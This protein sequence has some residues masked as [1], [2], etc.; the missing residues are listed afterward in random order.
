MSDKILFQGELQMTAWGESMTT[1]SWVKFWVH[2]EDMDVFKHKLRART[3]KTTGTRIGSVMVEIGDDEAIVEHQDTP[4]PTPAPPPLT[5][6]AEKPKP[7]PLGDLGKWAVM[8]CRDPRFQHWVALQLLV[9][10]DADDRAT[11]AD[12]KAFILDE[13]GAT[14]RYGTAASRKHLDTDPQCRASFTARV[15]E[16]YR[17][18]YQQQGFTE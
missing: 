15:L 16:P 9:D 12:C 17:V 5:P 4:G 13:C 2:P 3:G 8:R 11:D 14:V 10:A 1:G 7:E 18:Y 6:A